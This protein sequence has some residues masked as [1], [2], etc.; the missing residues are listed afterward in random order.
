MLHEIFFLSTQNSAVND[1]PYSTSGKAYAQTVETVDI[2]EVQEALDV[3]DEPNISSAI[4]SFMPKY[5]IGVRILGTLD[6]RTGRYEGEVSPKSGL[7][8]G[9]GD[10]LFPNGHSFSG[11]WK[12]GKRHGFGTQT[13]TNGFSYTGEWR[14]DKMEGEGRMKVSG[15]KGKLH[16]FE[17]TFTN[18]LLNG[19]ECKILFPD[20]KL[21]FGQV[22]ECS[23]SGFGK[24]VKPSGKVYEGEWAEN[25]RHGYG[26][27]TW[28][29][30]RV[31]GHWRKNK[32]QSFNGG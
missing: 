28:F 32:L 1:D 19:P 9:L 30:K 17:G 27:E 10:K 5:W 31:E 18:G 23:R 21:Y 8:H 4:L 11:T 7:N 24:L 6:C 20:G 22:K 25:K 3:F 14:N 16:E 15:P 13:W 26:V 12:E 2:D 29:G